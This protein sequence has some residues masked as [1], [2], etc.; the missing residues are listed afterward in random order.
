MKLKKFISPILISL[1][2]AIVLGSSLFF[3]A[4]Q[5]LKE[6]ILVSLCVSMLVYFLDLKPSAKKQPKPRTK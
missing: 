2:I 4:G 6:S 5:A 1:S 3:L